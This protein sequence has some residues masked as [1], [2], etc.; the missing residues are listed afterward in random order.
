M[1]S[2]NEDKNEDE[3]TKILIDNKNNNQNQKFSELN[4]EKHVFSNSYLDLDLN[5]KKN[6]LSSSSLSFISEKIKFDLDQF[7]N[8]IG[9][10]KFHYNILFIISLIFFV[11]SCEIMILNIMLS[12][13]SNEFL[14]NTIHRSLLSSSIFL[15]YFIGSFISGWLTN[16]IGRVKPIKYSLPFLFI[17]SLLTGFSPNFLLLFTIRIISGILIGIIAPSCV[18]LLAESIPTKYRSLVMNFAWIFYPI[19]IIYICVISIYLLR[20]QIFQW[21]TICITSSLSYVPIMTLSL[22][23]DESPRYLLLKGK[24]KEL[25]FLLNKIGEKNNPKI[26][27]HQSEIED[28]KKMCQENIFK[29]EKYYCFFKSEDLKKLFTNTQNINNEKNQTYT[30]TTT[31]ILFFL[32]LFTSY[33]IFGLIF[34]IPKIFE[35]ITNLENKSKS[36]SLRQIIIAMFIITP[37]PILRGSISELKFIGRKYAMAIGYLFTLLCCII[38]LYTDSYLYIFAGILKFMIN[39]SSGILLIYTSEV[40]ETDVRS[41]ALGVM[42]SLARLGGFS[43]PFICEF[44]DYLIFRGSFYAFTVFSFICIILSLSLPIETWGRSL[45]RLEENILIKA[46]VTNIKQV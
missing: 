10:N 3:E 23:L 40:Y 20:G 2:K 22:F 36:E 19:G 44:F 31:F 35:N 27:L 46:E 43:T 18:I 39:F 33:I 17:C 26:F 30:G 32:N 11:E 45:D 34:I 8:N 24:F 7:L 42:S 21:R 41:I 1:K 9:Y 37:C 4:K 15:G 25:V 13:I 28:L 38:C 5:P 6:N 16:E 12:T 14:L 29:N